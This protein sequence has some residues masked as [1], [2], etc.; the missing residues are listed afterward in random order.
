MIQSNDKMQKA[1]G[2]NSKRLSSGR[3]ALHQV[4]TSH[5]LS[6]TTTTLNNDDVHALTCQLD[7]IASIFSA[8]LGS[9]LRPNSYCDRA[10]TRFRDLSAGG[11]REISGAP[12]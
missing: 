7:I 1:T 10:T 3:T 8:L 11:A 4:R 6:A 2:L 12:T 9:I 5:L